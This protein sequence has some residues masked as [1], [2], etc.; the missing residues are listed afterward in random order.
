M[1]FTYNLRFAGQYF[2]VETG[3]HYNYYRTYDPS[4]GRYLESDPIGLQGGLNTY[5]YVGGN[6]LS[7]IDPLGLDIVTTTVSPNPNT[8]LATPVCSNGQFGIK[9]FKDDPCIKDC[10]IKHEMFHID[11]IRAK[12]PNICNG[13]VFSY[14]QYTAAD[15]ARREGDEEYSA[16][17][18][19][20]RCLENKTKMSCM[21][22]ECERRVNERI[23]TLKN[24]LWGL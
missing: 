10:A 24:K 18:L 5:G 8:T 16:N 20:L 15:F 13:V 12:R 3:L 6:P 7:Y 9:F 1:L 21:T 19:E 2:D 11:R 23:A 22:E 4:T 17:F 14:F